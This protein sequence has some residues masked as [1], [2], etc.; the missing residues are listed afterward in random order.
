MWNQQSKQISCRNL[1][2]A[3][4]LTAI[5]ALACA[6]ITPRADARTKFD[7][8][9]GFSFRYPSAWRVATPDELVGSAQAQS[10]K[11]NLVKPVE[12]MIYNPRDATQNVNVI[13][14]P[15]ISLQPLDLELLRKQVRAD[16][17]GSGVIIK[18]FES[19]FV[20]LS[21]RRALESSWDVAVERTL[22]QNSAEIFAT[23]QVPPVLT[24]VEASQRQLIVFGTNRSYVITG[25]AGNGTKE[26]LDAAFLTVAHSFAVQSDAIKSGVDWKNELDEMFERSRPRI[27]ESALISHLH[28]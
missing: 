27:L 25:S 21:S 18:N 2:V 10:H 3:V 13:S 11:L 17:A 19:R 8:P 9:G 6:Q 4:A 16:L 14:L 12:V 22:T 5:S 28:G 23:I 7:R 24:S 15:P 20:S 26:E 1:A